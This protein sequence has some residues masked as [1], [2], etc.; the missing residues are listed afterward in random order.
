MSNLLIAMHLCTE[1]DGFS[2]PTHFSEIMSSSEN[3]VIE[4]VDWFVRLMYHGRVH[5]R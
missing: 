1:C 5:T 2:K 4:R 3:H